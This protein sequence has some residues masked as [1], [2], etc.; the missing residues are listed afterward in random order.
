M[1]SSIQKS[2]SAALEI[3]GRASNLLATLY[4]KPAISTPFAGSGGFFSGR[5]QERDDSHLL[6]SRPNKDVRDIP[7]L[8]LYFFYT[9][10]GYEIY[11]RDNDPHPPNFRLS[12]G[13]SG[14]LGAVDRNAEALTLFELLD[15]NNNVITLDNLRGNHHYVKLKAIDGGFIGR[16]KIH[17]SRFSYTAD[18]GTKSIVTF[19]LTIL[20]THLPDR[21]QV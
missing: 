17:G 16:A 1:T 2:F 8:K 3:P 9:S 5:P 13:I 15:A 10:K 14:I 21:S 7:P 11:I 20:A 6:G 19:N 4:G 18:T 12:K